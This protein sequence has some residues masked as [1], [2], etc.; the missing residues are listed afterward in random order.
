MM[1]TG[2]ADSRHND[3]RPRVGAA[4]DVL[5]L[6]DRKV[7]EHGDKPAL[8]V[9]RDGNGSALSYADVH[10]RA[11]HMAARMLERGMQLDDRVAI[12]SES[13]P[14]WGVAFFA[15]IRAG[16]T[17]VPLDVQLT[18]AELSMILRDAEPRVLF[19]SPRFFEV[20]RRLC[21][22]IWSIREVVWLVD[23]D[24]DEGKKE[25]LEEVVRRYP[26][27]GAERRPPF[28]PRRPTDIAVLTYPSG[29]I[30][31]S[32]GVGTTFS[33]LVHQVTSL[34]DAFGGPAEDRVLSILPLHHLFTLTAGFLSLLWTGSEIRY[35]ESLTS[36]S[37]ASL[38][39]TLVRDWTN[40]MVNWEVMS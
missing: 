13:K 8:S 12:L 34:A 6:I 7:A 1:S 33:T 25:S 31:E 2:T 17:V 4:I 10:S 5:H 11:R 36:T 14:E 22:E 38:R 18:P 27:L 26:E 23:D 35:C 21:D 32:K 39:R 15:A 3:R 28:P 9:L 37:T 40:R 16:G 24:Q 20:A 29:T 30:D 19:A